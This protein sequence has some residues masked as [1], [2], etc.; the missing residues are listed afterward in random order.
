MQLH[1]KHIFKPAFIL[2]ALLTVLLSPIQITHAT[3]N[4]GPGGNEVGGKTPLELCRDCMDEG[5]RI[6]DANAQHEC[7]GFTYP[8]YQNYY[9]ACMANQ[10]G[11]CVDRYMVDSP[12]WC[13]RRISL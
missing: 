11:Y 3:E 1:S 13:T 9:N 6:C 4:G 12:L 5:H 2:I 7:N 10:H 8:C